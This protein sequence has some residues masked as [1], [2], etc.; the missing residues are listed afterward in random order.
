M[1]T[2]TALQ[3]EVFCTACLGSHDPT[4][5][6]QCKGRRIVRVPVPVG[7][8]T[9]HCILRD[10]DDVRVECHTGTFTPAFLVGGRVVGVEFSYRRDPGYTVTVSPMDTFERREDAVKV[11]VLG[12]RHKIDA[13]LATVA[14][15]EAGQ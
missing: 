15:L 3:E 14:Q 8:V 12:C 1:S 10:E 9:R 7:E 4:V 6:A 11:A 2:A 5:C 13:L